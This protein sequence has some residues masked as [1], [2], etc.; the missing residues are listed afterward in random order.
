[1]QAERGGAEGAGLVIAG[2]WGQPELGSLALHGDA[3]A[4]GR[5]HAPGTWENGDARLTGGSIDA[6][7]VLAEAQGLAGRRADDA[8][9]FAP[10]LEGRCAAVGLEGQAAKT[11]DACGAA[12]MDFHARL[13]DRQDDDID[14]A[15]QQARLAGHADGAR[16]LLVFQMEAAVAGPGVDQAA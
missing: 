11:L 16:A 3:I 7:P 14:A 5:Q 10:G 8:V 9:V 15:V 2:G 6:P 12:A 4:A 1:H 13:A